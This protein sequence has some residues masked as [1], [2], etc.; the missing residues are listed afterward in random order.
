MTQN[1]LP[2]FNDPHAKSRRKFHNT[3]SGYVI[4][5]LYGAKD[6]EGS[7]IPPKDGEDDGHGRWYGIETEGNYRMFSWKKSAAEGGETEYGTEFKDDA[8]NVMKNDIQEKLQLAREAEEIG[9]NYEGDDGE[10]RLNAIMEK[11]NAMTDWETP[12]ESEYLARYERAKNRFLD[13]IQYI[14]QNRADKEDIIERAKALAESTNW[15]AVQNEFRN[16]R[17]DLEMIG[18]AGDDA[19]A[20]IRR[21]FN[22]LQD[23]FRDRR[24]EYYN[25]LDTLRAEAKEKKEAIIAEAE[26]VVKNVT[27]WKNAG[28]KMNDLFTNWKEAGRADREI[29]DELWERFNA[30]RQEFNAGRQAFFEERNSSFRKSAEAKTALIERAKEIADSKVFS[31]ENTEAMK[32]LD[33]EWKAA[34][35]SG[36]E[37]ND[38]LWNEFTAVKNVFWDGK[39][40]E[41]VRRFKDAAERKQASAD[42]LKKEI[43][44]LEFKITITPKP[45][46]KR[47]I[48]MEADSRKR[49]L[50]V[51]EKDIADLKKK[52][53]E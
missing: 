43:E 5:V 49:S 39:H 17:D 16:L 48:E 3:F 26:K 6:A 7:P 14:R 1:T 22:K 27:N 42:A 38:R 8:L 50:E 10:E 25:S 11:W 21:Q 30:L 52:I 53:G 19:D 40:E 46:M 12:K 44:D 41:A 2:E 35:Y 4:E 33:L 36:K 20:E 32:K 31:K 24:K 18:S 34:G 29:D 15:K 45:E 13:R 51:L 37:D 9:R 28:A 23:D 47:E